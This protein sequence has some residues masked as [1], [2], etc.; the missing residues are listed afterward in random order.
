[1]LPQSRNVRGISFTAQPM[2]NTVSFLPRHDDTRSKSRRLAAL[3]SSLHLFHFRRSSFISGIGI[4]PGISAMDACIG[5]TAAFR[6][7][8][9]F[10]AKSAFAFSSCFSTAVELCNGCSLG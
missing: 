10:V 4:N 6:P 2:Q 8:C 7:I 5:S 9:V 1:M 3:N